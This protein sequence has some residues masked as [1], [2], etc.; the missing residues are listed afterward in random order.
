L[1]AGAAGRVGEIP[2]NGPLRRKASSSVKTKSSVLVLPFIVA[3][4]V[5]SIIR[6]A[7]WYCSSRALAIGEA[8]S[9][10]HAHL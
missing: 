2:T 8:L 3:N 4:K 7:C 9:S 1:G 5:L 6:E 10:A